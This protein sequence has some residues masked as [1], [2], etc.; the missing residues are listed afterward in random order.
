[1][2]LLY[3][4]LFSFFSDIWDDRKPEQQ[5]KLLQPSTGP[6][7][8]VISLVILRILIIIMA[9]SGIIII[10][11]IYVG[12]DHHDPDLDKGG[13]HPKEIISP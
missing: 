9:L 4:F 1:M 7:K 10:I 8:K 2:F 11:M 6:R 12:A 3:F 5:C 13:N